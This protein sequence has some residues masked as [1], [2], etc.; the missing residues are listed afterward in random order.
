[1]STQ[2]RTGGQLIVDQLK[3]HGVD[4][5]FCVPGESYLAVL[6]AL[7]DAPAIRVV[8]C[9]QE[10]GAAMMADAYGKLTNRPG[11]CMVTRGPGACNASA[12]LHVAMQDSTPMILFIGQVASDQ[13]EREAFQELDYRRMLGQLTK[14]TCQIDDP[15]RIPELV[16]RAFQVATSGRPGPVAIALPEDMLRIVV[17]HVGD[18]QPYRLVE[19]W[20]GPNQIDALRDLLGKAG[21]PFMLL[22]GAPWDEASVSA[23]QRFAQANRLPVATTF[24]R[25]D[26][27]DNAHECYAGDLGIGPNP[28]LVERL[29]ASDL[30]IVV[31][32][33]L[34]EMTTGGYKL[35]A[36][37]TPLQPLIHIH[38]DPEELGRVY[39]PTL[40]INATP[41]EFAHMVATMEPI[42]EP[43]WAATPQ[44]AHAEYLAWQKCPPT[45]GHIQLGEVV[46]WL[47]ANM[48]SETIY[49]NGAGNFTVWLHR[50]HQY[51]RFG[52]ELA[53]TSGSMGYG[54]PAALA[55]KLV[56]PGS[57][58]ICFA[59][60][61]DFMMTSQEMA[62]AVAYG[63][64]VIV[65]LINN[66]MYGTI[67]MHQENHYP[68]RVIATDLHNPDFA[69]FAKSFGA[70][71]EIVAETADF[72]PAFRRA[73]AFDGPAVLELRVDAEAITPR[74][75]LTS[76]R[77]AALAKHAA[78]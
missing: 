19:S 11:I 12:G 14:W 47:E 71:G 20:P 17:E 37:P 68:G 59:G 51:R 72:A 21:R 26:R 10:G 3:V 5:V 55:A 54:F 35:L 60:D 75:T 33:R 63:L 34:T 64:K 15:A 77:N 9:R 66:G 70:Y 76:L 44:E 7:N 41:R 78:V 1:M 52:T 25:A 42:A 48:P 6:D 29:N 65:I 53:P 24:R 18:A 32:G 4:T 56:R 62:T 36:I 49:T 58:V 74:A 16:A 30:L 73:Q 46:E 23:I 22:G 28:K 39:Q 40:A 69:L 2:R 43:R 13:V 8:S 31:G 67:R 27:F 50:F 38:P 61:G 45:P 57:P